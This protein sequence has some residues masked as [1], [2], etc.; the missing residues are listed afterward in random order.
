M[1]AQFSP[2]VAGLWRLAKWSLSPEA[3]ASWT[4]DVLDQGV[5]TFDL[6]DIYGSYTCE[7]LFGAALRTAPGLRDKLRIV[8]KCGI[9]V[10]SPQRPAHTRH[11]YDTSRAHIVSS[12]EASLRALGTDRID[13]LLLHRQDPLMDPDDVAAAF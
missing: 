11:A 7:G 10:V 8:T 2:I 3:L 4:S 9:K 6:A 12:V 5:D 1:S 13:V